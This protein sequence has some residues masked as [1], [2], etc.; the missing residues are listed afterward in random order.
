MPVFRSD[1]DE[2]GRRVRASGLSSLEPDAARGRGLSGSGVRSP[3]VLRGRF[4]PGAG[5]PLLAASCSKRE[6]RL[7]TAGG[8]VDSMSGEFDC[9]GS[10]TVDQREKEDR[11]RFQRGEGGCG[12]PAR[13]LG[14]WWLGN[15]L[16]EGDL[17]SRLA[18]P[19]YTPASNVDLLQRVASQAPNHYTPL[20]RQRPLSSTSTSFIIFPCLRFIRTYSK[21]SPRATYQV[22]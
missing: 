14:R 3:W 7:L 8:G 6:R 19:R 11:S 2:V 15:R 5:L 9:D 18:Q 12:E 20:L 21:L 10:M 4:G 17:R 13:W 1:E 16:R 22:S